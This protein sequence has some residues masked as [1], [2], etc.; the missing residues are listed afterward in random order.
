MLE[1]LNSVEIRTP[2]GEIAASKAG[3]GSSVGAFISRIIT[4]QSMRAS[5]A[6]AAQEAQAQVVAQL[7]E[8]VTLKSGVNI[9]EEMARL[10]ELQTAY[11]AN[12]RVLTAFQEMLSQLM[13]I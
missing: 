6:N 11:Q 3:E 8:R 5:S 1:R 2:N 9:D 7:E 13:E 4:T 12:A 10:V